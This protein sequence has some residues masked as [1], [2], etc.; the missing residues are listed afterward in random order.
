MKSTNSPPYYLL[1]QIMSLS[2]TKSEKL[3]QLQKLGYYQDYY[4][5]MSGQLNK[6]A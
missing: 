5:L 4:L 3:Q 6:K 2:L 1:K